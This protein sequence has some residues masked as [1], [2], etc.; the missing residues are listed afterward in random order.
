MRSVF[1]RAFCNTSMCSPSRATLL[2]G[3]Y[4][5]EHGVTLTHTQAD[6]RPDPRNL[7]AVAT[8]LFDILRAPGRAEL[9]DVGARAPHA[10]GFRR[11]RVLPRAVGRL[12]LRLD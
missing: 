12:L 1:S 2:T 10:E 3:L 5:A 11:E 9:G 7:P 6:L 8:T 4:P